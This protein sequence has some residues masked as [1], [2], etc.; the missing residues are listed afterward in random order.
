[1]IESGTAHMTVDEKSNVV[2]VLCDMQQ[3][4]TNGFSK[5]SS[6]SP[7]LTDDDKKWLADAWKRWRKDAK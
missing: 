3:V 4:A 7:K 5:A 1:M 6:W 2:M